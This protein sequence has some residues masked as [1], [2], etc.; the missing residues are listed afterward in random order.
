[1]VADRQF[2]SMGTTCRVVLTG[3]GADAAAEAA[4]ALVRSWAAALTRFDAGSELSRLNAD[5]RPV[6][7][8][9]EALRAFVGAAVWAGR[10]T[11]GLVD[12]TLVGE[13]EAAG[14][15][16]AASPPGGGW[17]SW[18]AVRA[19]I[20]PRRPAAP[21][22]WWIGVRVTDDAVVRP[23]GLWLDSG[24]IAKG[25][26]ADR[27]LAGEGGRELAFCDCGGDVAVGGAGAAAR[28]WEVAV[29]HPL[30][31][32]VA[33]RFRLASGGVASSGIARRLWL[34]P[35]G[36]PA[37]HL[38]DPATGEPAW[39]GLVSASAVGRSALEAE[40]LAKAA[41]LSGPDRARAVLAARGGLLVHEDG[42]VEAIAPER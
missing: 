36:T 1:V 24:G 15:A 11:G 20:P 21:R 38:L 41:Y 6:V 27:V 12:P 35:D 23:P 3:P 32:E 28:P 5:P 22:S 8:A 39:T 37:H 30:T 18:D 25:L 4:E 33:H 42:D 19:R 29:R 10:E 14:Y 17:A 9:G 16:G 13:I 2:E 26:I 34:R 7:P 31:G 40:A